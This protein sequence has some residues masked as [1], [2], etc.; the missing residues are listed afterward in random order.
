MGECIDVL[1][2][3]V[4]TNV[5]GKWHVTGMHKIIMLS[6]RKSRA[7]HV[8]A[9]LRSSTNALGKLHVTGMHKI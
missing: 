5:L 6:D 9:A 4:S 1:V 2:L 8:G 7:T 3:K